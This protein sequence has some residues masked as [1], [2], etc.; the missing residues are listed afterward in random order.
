MPLIKIFGLG[1]GCI[2]V[3]LSSVAYSATTFDS[4]QI[5]TSFDNFTSISCDATATRCLAVGSEFKTKVLDEERV[6]ASMV[7]QVYRTEDGAHTWSEPQVLSHGVYDVVL[8]GIEGWIKSEVL[9]MEANMTAHCSASGLV[10]FVL[11]RV[12]K[13]LMI[14]IIRL[15]IQHMMVA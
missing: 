12:L 9:K 10:C 14:N 7:N 3:L 11:L 2:G 6:S 1:V 4:V 5:Q 13:K 15:F 8:S